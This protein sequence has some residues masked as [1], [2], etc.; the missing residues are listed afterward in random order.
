MGYFGAQP[1]LHPP[2][3]VRH[4]NK[5]SDSYIEGIVSQV[6]AHSTCVVQEAREGPALV[7]GEAEAEGAGDR[8][9]LP[10]GR[11]P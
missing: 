11:N 10:D 1:S 9:Q 6:R 8:S 7:A 4:E 3:E 2:V 5:N